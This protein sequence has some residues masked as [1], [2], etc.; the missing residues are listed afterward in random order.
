MEI[1]L[2]IEDFLRKKDCPGTVGQVTVFFT[3]KKTEKLFIDEL[4]CKLENCRNLTMD[5]LLSMVIDISHN[6]RHC[7]VD[8]LG[9]GPKSGGGEWYGISHMVNCEFKSYLDLDRMYFIINNAKNTMLK[10][11]GEEE[12]EQE[13]S[14]YKNKRY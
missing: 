9:T 5:S 7:I 8:S 3:E 12:T 10:D 4:K 1:K 14:K 13:P 11:D 6:Y 2:N